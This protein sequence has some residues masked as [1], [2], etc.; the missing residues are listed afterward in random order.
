MTITKKDIQPLK[1]AIIAD[2]ARFTSKALALSESEK[3]EKIEHFSK[4]QISEGKLYFKLCLKNGSVWGFVVK[5]DGGKFK[6]GDIL[7]AASWS[8]PAKNFAR[9]NI[10][11]TLNH[12]Q[13]MGA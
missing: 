8:S 13:W 10:F 4:M 2:Y 11:E 7:K 3:S 9:G 5:N 1:E 6:A 12:F